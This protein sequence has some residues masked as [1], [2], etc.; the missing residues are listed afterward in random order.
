MRIINKRAI[1]IAVSVLLGVLIIVL[2][3]FKYPFA[4]VIST[5]TNITFKLVL[6]YLGVSAL[7]MVTLSFRWKVILSALGHKIPFYKLIGYRIIGYGISYI[8]P[9]AKVG[10]EPLRAALLKRQGLSFREGLSTVIIDK[11]LELSFSAIF[12]FCGV[13]IILI[14]YAVPGE[15][16]IGMLLLSGFFICLVFVFYSRILKGKPFFA[17]LFRLVRL[18]KLKFLAKYHAVILK[19]EEPIIKFYKNKRKEFFITAGVSLV[20]LCLSVL[21][22][23]LVLLMIGVNAPLGVAFLVFSIAGAAFLIPLP[24]ALGSMEAFQVSLFSI[25]K[26]GPAAGG[27]GVAMITRSRDLL[28]LLGALILS[29]YLGSFK[30]IIRKAYGDKPIV[31]ITVFRN[32]RKQRMDIKINRPK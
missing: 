13:L 6:A 2:I 25:L 21:E 8:T 26:L 31:G 5:F 30:N 4:E 15:I 3:L 27:I 28:W 23:K 9:S 14:T 1:G 17:Y 19:F 16:L 32:G 22:F 10:G 7:I 20:S 24:M 11:L 29:F 18:H 12:F